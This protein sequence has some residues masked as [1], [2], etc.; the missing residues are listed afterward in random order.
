MTYKQKSKEYDWFKGPQEEKNKNIKNLK[1]IWKFTKIFLMFSLFFFSMWGCVQVFVIKSDN[2]VGSGIEFYQS[3]SKI[4]PRVNKFNITKSSSSIYQLEF[5]DSN[6]WLSEKKGDKLSLIQKQIIEGTGFKGKDIKMSDAHYGS[7]E[8]YSLTID[9]KKILNSNNKYLAFSTVA[10]KSTLIKNQT[11]STLNSLKIYF[12]VFET[13]KEKKK[14]SIFKEKGRIGTF[15]MTSSQTKL[16]TTSNAA[17]WNRFSVLKYFDDVLKSN[18]KTKHLAPSANRG[19]FIDSNGKY[20][21]AIELVHHQSVNIILKYLKTGFEPKTKISNNTPKLNFTKEYFSSE[22][23]YKP[24]V[25]WKHAWVRGVGPFYG[26]FVFPISKVSTGILNSFPILSGWESLISIIIIVFLLR[27]FA[28]ILTFK[29]VL[30]QTKQQELQA[31]KATIDA[32]YLNYKGNKQ[33]EARQKQEIAELYKR[34]GV[35]P[36][37]AIGSVFMTMPIFLSIWRII[38]GLP[39][40]KSTIWL[41][42]NFSA[43]SYQNLFAGE[44]QYLPLIILAGLSSAFSQLFPRLL[45]KKR[46]GHRINV[47]QKEAMKK[48]NK[49]QNIVLAV[50]VFMALIFS[51]GIQI[52]WIIG[53]I[54]QIIQTTLTHQIIIYQ[55]KWK[56][57]KMKK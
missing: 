40:L 52:Y 7:N 16:N 43:T 45:N 57:K 18:Y 5:I 36:L 48:N 42:I 13:D 6:E 8:Y 21:Q 12:P 25:N 37:G 27:I 47:Q 20:S 3:E 44:W 32:K 2:K 31:K 22:T 14:N 56:S 26:L 53:A 49:T 38:G 24:I 55:K 54:W 51:A 50:F 39:Q 4:S 34:E 10:K 19:D 41:G 30:Q 11:N 15:K 23:T 33:M 9:N 28:F 35:S 46:D 17:F 29:S 1:I